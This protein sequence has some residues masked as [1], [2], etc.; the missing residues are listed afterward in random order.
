MVRQRLT[1]N[2]SGNEEVSDMSAK[3]LLRD[4][5]VYI[6]V[7]VVYGLMGLGLVHLFQAVWSLRSWVILASGIIAV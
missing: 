4:T 6:V 2:G 7:T 5:V 3:R 1:I